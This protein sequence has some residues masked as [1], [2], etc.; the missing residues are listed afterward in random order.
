[1]GPAVL[2]VLIS[3]FG[4]VFRFLRKSSGPTDTTSWGMFSAEGGSFM[5]VTVQIICA[6]SVSWTRRPGQAH[7]MPPPQGP[8]KAL[9]LGFGGRGSGPSSPSH[10]PHGPGESAFQPRASL[11]P[12]VKGKGHHEERP[13]LGWW[14]AWARGMAWPRCGQH[15]PRWDCCATLSTS[16]CPHSHPHSV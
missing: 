10:Q 2:T 14:R 16:P 7:L 1:M 13:A 9:G 5:R 3:Y 8:P 6:A 12:S 11:P 15:Q 4:P